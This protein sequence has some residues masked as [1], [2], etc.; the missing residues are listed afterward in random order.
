MPFD[1]KLRWVYDE[2]IIPSCN[3]MGIDVY[4]ADDMYRHSNVIRDIVEGIIYSDLVIADLTGNNPN[5]FYELGA[6]H[7]LMR[8]VIILIQGTKNLPFDLRTHRVLTYTPEKSQISNFRLRLSKTLKETAKIQIEPSS[9]IADYMPIPFAERIHQANKHSK[10]IGDIHLYRDGDTGV[11]VVNGLIS[12]GLVIEPS[13]DIASLHWGSLVSGWGWD[14][15]DSINVKVT[16][17]PKIYILYG[18]RTSPIGDIRGTPYVRTVH[19]ELIYFD[20]YMW[21]IHP[22]QAFQ[23]T[24]TLDR[25][26]GTIEYPLSRLKSSSYA[27]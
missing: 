20:L 4:R 6:A 3:D 13:Y 7:A 24:L 23:K 5:V 15:I 26:S 8:P 19:K 21:R 11:L 25:H 18:L 16:K 14:G 27:V 22:E 10:P 2:V 9:P 17:K 12:L 1:P